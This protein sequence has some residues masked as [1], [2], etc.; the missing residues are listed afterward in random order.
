MIHVETSRQAIL[1]MSAESRCVLPRFLVA[2]VG[3]AGVSGRE[4][5][6]GEEGAFWST[7]R[8]GLVLCLALCFM[9]ADPGRSPTEV[10]QS[11]DADC[12][13]RVHRVSNAVSDM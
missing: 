2:L 11:S 7:L 13:A 4:V 10:H 3:C 12:A 6:R 9:A 8:L 1:R 5:R